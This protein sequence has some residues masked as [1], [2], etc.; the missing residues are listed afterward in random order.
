MCTG[1]QRANPSRTKLM[2][3]TLYHIYVNN[4][5]VRASLNEDDFHTELK[6]IKGFLELTNLDKS[7]KVDYVQC[8]PPT[9]AEASF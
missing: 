6:H 4:K 7:A 1:G 9:Y 3:D 8:D 5:C 2:H